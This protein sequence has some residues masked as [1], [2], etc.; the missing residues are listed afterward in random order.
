[1][2][3]SAQRVVLVENVEGSSSAGSIQI[4]KFTTV[5]NSD[6]NAV[7]SAGSVVTKRIGAAGNSYRVQDAIAHSSNANV[8][9]L[10]VHDE[11]TGSG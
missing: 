4:T 1:M 11:T 3:N 10:V 5:S 2:L 6:H 7:P 8:V 9:Y